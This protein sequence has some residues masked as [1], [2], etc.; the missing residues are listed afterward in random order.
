MTIDL[1]PFAGSAANFAP[2]S[3]GEYSYA[4]N[5]HIGVRVPRR[6]DIPENESAPKAENAFSKAEPLLRSIEGAS[7]IPALP[8]IET[9][10]CHVCK[11]EG[12]VVK[13]DDC[14]GQGFVECNLGHEHEC[15]ECGEQG[16]VSARHAEDASRHMPCEECDGT[17]RV[18]EADS[19]RGVYVVFPGEHTVQLRYL[20]KLQKLPG[21][22][23]KLTGREAADPIP[24]WFEGGDGI[25]MPVR[26]PGPDRNGCIYVEDSPMAAE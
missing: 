10:R 23:W 3:R 13:C 11:G 26:Y 2:F 6:D 14:D 4:T 9:K 7:P 18:P 8:P 24:F 25:L 5:G 19:G 17:G 21:I 20:N 22:R 16:V 12:K 15:E 1:L